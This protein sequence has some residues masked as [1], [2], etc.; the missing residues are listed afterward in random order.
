MSFTTVGL[1][2]L[3][4]DRFESAASKYVGQDATLPLSEG[5]NLIRAS[6]R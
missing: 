2:R 6:E 5:R 3:Q 4:Q 1:L